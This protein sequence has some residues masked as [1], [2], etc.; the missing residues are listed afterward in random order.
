MGNSTNF[1]GAGAARKVAM[2]GGTFAVAMGIGFFMQNENAE[3]ALTSPST[4]PM[5]QQAPAQDA[6][7]NELP[8]PLTTSSAIAVPS[9]DTAIATVIEASTSPAL[10]PEEEAAPEE[11]VLAVAPDEP[12][13]DVMMSAEV[14]DAALVKL[15]V[16]TPCAASEAF[17][18]HHEGMMFSG[19]TDADGK[20]TIFAPAL[21]E[22][23]LFIAAFDAGLGA[24]A[25]ASVPELA[26]YDRVVLQW[27]GEGA[28]EIH[29][30]E[31][32]ASYGDAG[33][34][35]YA[36]PRNAASAE[37]GD[38][39]FLL[40]LG[41]GRVE[42][43]RFAQVYTFPSGNALQPGNIELSVE[44][45]ITAE[46]CNSQVEAQ[47]LEANRGDSVRIVDLTLAVPACEA[48][49][50]FLVLKNLLADLTLQAG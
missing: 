14:Q 33:H 4:L 24:L 15:S 22:A 42:D 13:C 6:L 44:A 31:Y 50:D 49:G 46:N 7:P 43:P 5:P 35:W 41:D 32:G 25:E 20:A 12:V 36:A 40:A 29:A 3:A 10:E 11:E 8:Q 17:T 38:G 48:V 21:N 30:M 19:M 18:V 27:K 1:P 34:V 26:D 16:E 37:L 23:A 9:A 45:E 39:G 47:T 2:A 28:F